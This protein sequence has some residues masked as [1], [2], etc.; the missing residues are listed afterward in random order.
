MA[1]DIMHNNLYYLGSSL[2]Y[3]SLDDAQHSSNSRWQ[4]REPRGADQYSSAEENKEETILQDGNIL[5]DAGR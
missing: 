5:V 3:L 1:L 4:A 2:L